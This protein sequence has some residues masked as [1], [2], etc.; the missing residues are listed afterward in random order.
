MA[1]QAKPQIIAIEAVQRWR[2]EPG[3]VGER[4]VNTRMRVPIH[5]QLD[6]LR[7][8][9]GDG[10][11]RKGKGDLSKLP[12][13]LQYDTAPRITGTAPSSACPASR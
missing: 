9:G 8:G 3:R 6:H 5:F 7:D 1:A 12:E 10:L 4:P 2:F 13:A 11:E